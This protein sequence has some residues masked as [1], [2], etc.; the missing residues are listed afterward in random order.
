MVSHNEFIANLAQDLKPVRPIFSPG[1]R[2]FLWSLFSFL[3]VALSMFWVQQ[4]RPGFWDE[5]SQPSFF[6][7]SALAFLPFLTV[8]FVVLI[9]T[10]PGQSIRLWQVFLAISPFLLFFGALWIG[11]EG[12]PSIKPT[13]S[14]ARGDC[15]A[16]VLWFS[17]IPIFFLVYLVR[18][19]LA[20]RRFLIGGLIGLAGA[21][22]P[23][24]LMQIACMYDP[25]HAITHHIYPALIVTA[26]MSAVGP[27][28]LHFKKKI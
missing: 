21:S 24:A 20:P 27:I 14:G 9:L 8:T 12:H 16:E 13:I 19:A 28:L 3:F 1:K 11:R 18:K 15:F 25:Q 22:L 5:L 17:W 26:I 7:E 2:L 6:L 10:V 23:M 4:F